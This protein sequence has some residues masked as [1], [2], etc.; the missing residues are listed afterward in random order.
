MKRKLIAFS[1]LAVA[2]TS[3]TAVKYRSPQFG[4]RVVTHEQVAVLPFEMILTGKL[5]AGLTQGR[6]AEIEEQE[7]L[8]FQA[9]LYDALLD[10]S[11]KRK[12]PVRIELQPVSKTNRILEENGISVR[13]SWTM[14]PEDLADVLG[15]QAVVRTRIRKARYLSDGASLGIDLGTRVLDEVTEG[16]LTDLLP[17]GL[18]RTYDIFADGSLFDGADGNLLWKVGVERQSDWACPA[19]DVIVGVTRKLAKEFPYRT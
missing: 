5:P 13:E 17:F 8:A 16:T 7:S 19:N 14:T 9:A 11:G 1:L 10:Q 4:A 3:C 2:T 18:A 6:V 15:V 12:R